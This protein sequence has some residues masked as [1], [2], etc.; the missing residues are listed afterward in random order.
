MEQPSKAVIGT[1]IQAYLVAEDFNLAVGSVDR[2]VTP[3]IVAVSV[4]LKIQGQAF[5]SLLRR[6]IC[7]EA[8]HR[9]EN[10]QKRKAAAVSSDTQNPG[11]PLSKGYL[12]SA[13]TQMLVLATTSS[14]FFLLRHLLKSPRSSITFLSLYIS[15]W[16]GQSHFVQNRFQQTL[17]TL[18][19]LHPSFHPRTLKCHHQTFSKRNAPT[20][21]PHC[22]SVFSSI[23]VRTEPCSKKFMLLW[24]S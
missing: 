12:G 3:V 5:N 21:N 14:I 15:H 19:R 7:A 20:I 23:L 10:L 1:L 18:G 9:N 17:Q 6:K 2:F 24:V 11:W 8:V 13:K 22:S 16:R 4:N